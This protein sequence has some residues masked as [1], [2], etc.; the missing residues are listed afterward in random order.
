MGKSSQRK[1]RAAEIEVANILKAAGWSATVKGIYEPF[2]VDWEGYDCEVKRRK[3]SMSVKVVEACLG[4]GAF[5]VFYRFDR[6]PWR[7][8]H[9]LDEFI[10]MYGPK[11]RVS[12]LAG[13]G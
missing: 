4:D 10:R 3:D 5:A 8:V 9:D 13:E 7:V 2:D 6:K 12:P 1:G 11:L